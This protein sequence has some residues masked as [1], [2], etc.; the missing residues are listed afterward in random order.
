[1]HGSCKKVLKFLILH[2]VDNLV[3]FTFL[4]IFLRWFRG[5]LFTAVIQ[6]IHLEGWTVSVFTCEKS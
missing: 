5:P 4:S 6:Q 3:L 1:M 2:K